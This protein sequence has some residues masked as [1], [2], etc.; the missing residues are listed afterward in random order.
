MGDENPDI[1]KNVE[2]IGD[3]SLPINRCNDRNKT[4]LGYVKIKS[5]K[6]CVL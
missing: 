1:L 4:D 6:I 2:K 5:R 3:M